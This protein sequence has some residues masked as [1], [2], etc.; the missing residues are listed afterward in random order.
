M[1]ESHPILGYL[2]AVFMIV[3]GT[4]MTLWAGRIYEFYRRGDEREWERVKNWHYFFKFPLLLRR[5]SSPEKH[6]WNIR[7]CGAIL[8]LA[9]IILLFGLSYR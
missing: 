3:L 5:S 8:I 4:A 6:I 2:A 9:A 7:K 1:N